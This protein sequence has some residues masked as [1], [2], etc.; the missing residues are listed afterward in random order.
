MRS[1]DLVREFMERFGQPIAPGINIRDLDLNGL[2]LRLLAEELDEL[3]AALSAGDLVEVADALG[4]LQYVLDGAWIAFGL[5][6]H[7]DAVIEEIHRSNMTKLGR[8]GKPVVRADGKITKGPDFEE[9][10]LKR[11]LEG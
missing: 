2:R 9:P 1:I 6:K 7:K 11:V 4:D 3:S 10:D 5:A 8:D